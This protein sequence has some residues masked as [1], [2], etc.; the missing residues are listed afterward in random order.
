MPPQSGPAPERLLERARSGDT[1]ALGQLLQS[2]VSWLKLLAKVEID[3]RLRG[4]TDPSDVVQDVCLKAY[5]AFA[6]F[7][8]TSEREL[9][10]WLR[11]VLATTL[12]DLVKRYY[13]TQRRD[14]RLERELD[15]E[16]DRSSR[17]L[18]HAFVSRQS[19]PSEQAS[20]RE[21][22]VALA[23][24][25]ERLPNDYR[26]VIVLRHLESLTFPQ[27]ALR[28]ERSVDSVEKL[29]SRALL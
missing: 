9:L 14:V 4:K 24:A 26:E 27:V 2:Y 6:Q 8:G 25:L 13:K 18:N 12:V 21:Q 20:R 1:T 16:L 11:Q 29:W 19:T 10:G 22:G 7:R 3:R 15:G 5:R 28:M 23:E 17:L